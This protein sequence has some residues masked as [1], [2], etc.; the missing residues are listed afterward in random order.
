MVDEV[1]DKRGKKRYRSSL[2]K[3][4]KNKKRERSDIISNKI[5][6]QILG[7]DKGFKLK[8]RKDLKKRERF[9]L[10]WDIRKR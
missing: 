8:D 2:N 10:K 7:I 4:Q 6:A 5:I 1:L 3:K 9:I